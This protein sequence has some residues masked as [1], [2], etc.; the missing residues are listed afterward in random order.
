MQVPLAPLDQIPEGDTL[1]VDFFGREVLLTRIGGRPRAIVNTC[2]HLGGPLD[3][4]DGELVCAW[5]EARWELDGG[6]KLDG[7]GRDDARLL[8]LPIRTID[9]VVHY[10]YG[11]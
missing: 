5:H 9:G 1:P 7:P 4:R 8:H 3:C 11:D 2:L 6:R 10:V